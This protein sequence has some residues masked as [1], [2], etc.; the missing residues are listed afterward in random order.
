[1]YILCVIIHTH[2]HGIWQYTICMDS[3][4]K[5]NGSYIRDKY[6][7]RST[8]KIWYVTVQLLRHGSVRR[9]VVVHQRRPNAN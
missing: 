7:S 4:E 5:Q 3:P 9:L 1:M 8:D 6:N 2:N